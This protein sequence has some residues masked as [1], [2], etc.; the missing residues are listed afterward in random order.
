[1]MSTLTQHLERKEACGVLSFMLDAA[2]PKDNFN[3]EN[4]LLSGLNA[5]Y[6]HSIRQMMRLRFNKIN[7]PNW[8]RRGSNGSVNYHTDK[9]IAST[10]RTDRYEEITAER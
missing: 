5:V 3:A 2:L 7:L 4:R 9:L 1:M 8:L 6:W 10:N